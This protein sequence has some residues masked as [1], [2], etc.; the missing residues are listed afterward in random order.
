MS[1]QLAIMTFF[2]AGAFIFAYITFKLKSDVIEELIPKLLFLTFMFI[3][4]LNGLT[5]GQSILDNENTTTNP[6]NE[7]VYTSIT[8][9]FESSYLAILW[10]F[11]IIFAWIILM[12]IW[13]GKD[14]F[15]A[16]ID[17]IKMKK[18]RE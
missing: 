4:L 11:I 10:G 5:I 13:N 16:E 17:K 15:L 9:K 18:K 2:V 1:F 14:A 12:I 3:F 7:T 8:N 6:I